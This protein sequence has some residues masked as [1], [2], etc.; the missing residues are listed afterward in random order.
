MAKKLNFNTDYLFMCDVK[1]TVNSVI[2]E[3]D[4][5]VNGSF[6]PVPASSLLNYY[7]SSGQS[8]S[9]GHTATVNAPINTL[10]LQDAYLFNGVPAI[11]PGSTASVVPADVASTVAFTQP[12][13]ETH[14]YSL[15]SKLIGSVGG[16]W[17]VA[18][19]GRGGESIENLT[20]GTQPYNNGIIMRDGA[21]AAA[22]SLSL[23]GVNV[24]FATWIQ[25]ESDVTNNLSWYNSELSAFIDYLNTDFKTLNNG[26]AIPVFTTQVGTSGS[27]LFASNELDYSNKHPLVYCAGPNWPISRLHPNS[28]VDYTHLNAQGYIHLGSMLEA[29]IKQVVYSGNPSYKPFQPNS[30]KV[31][32]NSVE[33]DFHVPSGNVVIDTTTFPEAPMLGI[34]FLHG[35]TYSSST[36]SHKLYGNKLTLSYD[37]GGL[38]LAVGSTIE[39]GNTLTNH[40]STNGVPVPLIN[41]RGSKSNI[42]N[43]MDWCCQ[44][45]IKLTKEMGALDPDTDNVWT[46]GTPTINTADTFETVAGVS[47]CYFL[48]G[49]T[50]QVTYDSADITSGSVRIWVGDS[51]HTVVAGGASVVMTRG[52]TTRLRL[53]SGGSGFS[54]RIKNLVIKKLS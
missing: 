7:I 21:V 23:A 44:F 9:I 28:S 37:T 14:A 32:G 36:G 4:G 54:G 35:A 45:S 41:I 52:A 46:F 11:A 29:T 8:L 48:T 20:K 2:D 16:K 17:L 5:L 6:K 47:S 49:A 1:D 38:P 50:Y 22:S 53:Q 25:G 19:N 10:A 15:I 31:L 30:L 43:W 3:V 26:G 18:P 34:K 42:S 13:R 27:V 51:N 39:G 33:I 12:V 40:S 24:P